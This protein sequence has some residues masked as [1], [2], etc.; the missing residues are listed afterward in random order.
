MSHVEA[1]FEASA[2]RPDLVM[3]LGI[4]PDGL[5]RGGYG[6]IEPGELLAWSSTRPLRLVRGFHEKPSRPDSERYGRAGG[7][8]T[9]SSWSRAYPRCWR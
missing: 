9:A 6:W 4:V 2:E 7:S 1:A 5:D 3:L 8:G